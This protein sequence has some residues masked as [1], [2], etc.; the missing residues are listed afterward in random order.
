MNP[1]DRDVPL[2]RALFGLDAKRLRR[3]LSALVPGRD[4]SSI[5]AIAQPSPPVT[6]FAVQLDSQGRLARG[7]AEWR[8]YTGQAERD[9]LGEGFFLAIHPDERAGFRS[10]LESHLRGGRPF[11]GSTRIFAR[12]PGQHR[13][14]QLA[15]A[16]SPGKGAAW[17]LIVA[18]QATSPHAERDARLSASAREAELLRT[19]AEGFLHIVNN[20]L[21]GAVG[22]TALLARGGDPA[23]R[24]AADRIDEALARITRAG[25]KLVTAA[26]DANLRLALCDLGSS[27]L[28]WQPLLAD[29]C[30][31]GAR[32]ELV[33]GPHQAWAHSDP[34]SLS[35][36]LLCVV[37]NAAEA[38]PTGGRIVVSIGQRAFLARELERAEPP[39]HAHDGVFAFLEVNDEGTGIA[40][41]HLSRVFDPF[42]STK[43]IGRG[44]GLS[45]AR[46]LMRQMGGLLSV[47]SLPGQGTRVRLL[48]PAAERPA[49]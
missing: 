19:L 15:A 4:V 8:A 12:A 6:T 39:E 25:K 30:P 40:P 32:L 9:A 23:V 1:R 45:M 37:R 18:E 31:P 24:L 3:G 44:L 36:S 46:G 11:T 38:M 17:L 14:C 49:C 7:A 27:L 35:E 29:V 48:L 21:Q 26:A 10:L 34:Q 42:F 28:E 47:A 41:A 33:A 43:F 16:P 2:A 5:Q 22:Y 13:L 20:A